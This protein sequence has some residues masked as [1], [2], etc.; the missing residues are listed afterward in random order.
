MYKIIDASQAGLKQ[1]SGGISWNWII[2]FDGVFCMHIVLQSVLV[3]LLSYYRY[4]QGLL[5]FN[6]VCIYLCEDV[7]IGTMFRLACGQ[8]T[9]FKVYM[10]SV[11]VCV[12]IGL[13]HYHTLTNRG[14][15][16]IQI[17]VCI[18]SV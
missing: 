17:P 18:P 7:T 2:T 13:K 14:M 15:L 1:W 3:V 9:H 6:V 5:L 16:S 8:V 10:H 4:Y 11:Y 12:V